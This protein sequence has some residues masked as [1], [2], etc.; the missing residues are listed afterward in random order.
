MKTGCHSLS[1]L[2]HFNNRAVK[3]TFILAH[4]QT[5]KH[6]LSRAEVGHL[7]EQHLAGVVAHCEVPAAAAA[8]GHGSDALEGG[9]LGRPI[10]E[11]GAA[12]QVDQLQL[13][14]LLCIATEH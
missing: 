2:Q 6:N 8:E 9:L 13:V 4:R 7:V 12:R 1:Y 14:L 10:G 5:Q 11:H 3:A